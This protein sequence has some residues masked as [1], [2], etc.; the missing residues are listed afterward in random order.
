MQAEAVGSEGFHGALAVFGGKAVVEL[1]GTEVGKEN[2]V[3]RGI[4]QA[5]TRRG[6]RGGELH[7]L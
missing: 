1:D 4:A 6:G 5:E 7:P 2:G 3:W